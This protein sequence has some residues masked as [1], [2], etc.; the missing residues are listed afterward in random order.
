ML[1]TLGENLN[2]AQIRLLPVKIAQ[3]ERAYLDVISKR[4]F[5]F[6]VHPENN[7]K[8]WRFSKISADVSREGLSY[9]I[10]QIVLLS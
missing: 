1:W 10:F 2:S 4:E 9:L 5:S 7:K 8:Q 3:Q 6:S